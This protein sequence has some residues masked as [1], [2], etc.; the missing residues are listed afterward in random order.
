MSD[1]LIPFDNWR[2]ELDESIKAIQQPRTDFQIK[3]FVVGQHVSEPR[4]WW[5]CVLELQIKLQ[6]IRRAEIHQRQSRRKIE[7]LEK[8]GTPA[9]LDKA[10]LERIDLEDHSLAMLGAVREAQC[11]WGIYKSFDRTF[12]REE[13]EAA[14]S[15]YWQLRLAMQ[16]QHDMNANGRVG[17]GNQDAL[18]MIG[19]PTGQGHIK[20]AEQRFLEGGRLRILIVTPTLIDKETIKRDGLRCLDGWGVPGVFEQKFLVI[21]GKPVADAYNEAA[22]KAI[23]DEADYLLCVEDDHIIPQGTFEKVWAVH[24]KEG[25]RS[26][27]GAWYPQR[28]EPRTG[29]PIVLSDDRLFSLTDKS[30]CGAIMSKTTRGYLKDDGDVHEVYSI[31]QGFTLIPVQAFREIPQPWFVTTG[32]LTQDSFFSQQAREAGWKLFVGTSARIKH[33]DRETGRVYE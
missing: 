8:I 6:N 13:L 27:V 26:I 22:R 12:T 2:A 3:H 20:A 18:R 5:Q 30:A 1:D 16:A 24:Q 33:V 10:E 11:L 14:E 32:S 15:E 21:D 19:Q 29:A 31:P 7:R 28:K 23:E 17:V 4:R 25:P 9:A